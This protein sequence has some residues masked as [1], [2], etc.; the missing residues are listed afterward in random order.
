MTWDPQGMKIADV[1]SFTVT[2]YVMLVGAY[3]FEDPDDPRNFRKSINLFNRLLEKMV[4]RFRKSQTSYEET[5]VCRSLSLS[6]MSKSP[7]TSHGRF[8][9][10]PNRI[11]ESHKGL[12]PAMECNP[13]TKETQKVLREI[14][15]ILLLPFCFWLPPKSGIDSDPESVAPLLPCHCSVI[16][17]AHIGSPILSISWPKPFH[18][19]N[20]SVT[21]VESPKPAA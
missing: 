15:Q 7:T 6:T 1:W 4:H 17:S 9:L 16:A 19:I 5:C 11:S 21:P 14:I 13:Y 3:P 2:L 18:S 8:M 10:V 12:L 20:Q